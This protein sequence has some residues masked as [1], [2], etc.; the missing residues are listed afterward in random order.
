MLNKYV[1]ILFAVSFF[2][3]PTAY[4]QK[5][6]DSLLKIAN[7]MIYENPDLAIELSQ[8]AYNAPEV[9]IRNQVNALLAISIAYSSK[10]DYEKSSE[11]ILQI[12][13]L[14]PKINEETQ[15]MNILNRIAAHYQELQIYDKAKEYLDESLAL[16]EK[17]PNQDSIQ[18][19]LG[20]NSIVRGFIY[21]EQMNCEIALNYFNKA[22]EAYSKTIKNPIMNGNVS[23]C[24][25]NKGNCLLT[26]NKIEEAKESY[27]KSI[28]HARIVDA[29]SLIAFAQKGLAEAKTLEG[30]YTEA[31]SLL[32]NALAISE[33]V[34]DLI[35]NR[36]IYE[37]L[38]T[39]NLALNNWDNYTL[40]QN[41]FLDL[42]ERT[43]IA[44]RKTINQS[45]LNLV[46]VKA[47]EIEQI[48]SKYNPLQIALIIILIIAI[49]F[50]IHSIIKWEK[51]LKKLENNLKN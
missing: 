17:Y 4:S 2:L 20:Y 48:H 8:K 14:F 21:R 23:I 22:I 26:L 41:K 11:Y 28:E 27:Q 9:T 10:R 13:E 25:Y 44:E 31:I 34:G 36:G 5:S 12:K 16:I 40:Y 50:L 47:Q 29:K 39:N 51:T 33:N 30:N 6:V 38:A 43:K 42:K 46:A 3:A 35:L 45:M 32:N 1:L 37:R 15:K 7:K 49:L 19:F 24:Y 18:T